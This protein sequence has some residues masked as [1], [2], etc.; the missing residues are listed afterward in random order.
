MNRKKH[1]GK[2]TGAREKEGKGSVVRL[3]ELN[4][5]MRERRAALM[6]VGACGVAAKL[7]HRVS[8]SF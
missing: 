3:N 1:K 8:T 7:I 6:H 2:R 5:G 4:E